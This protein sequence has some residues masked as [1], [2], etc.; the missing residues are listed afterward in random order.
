MQSFER[1]NILTSN[2]AIAL[3]QRA[4]AQFDIEGVTILGGE[5]LLQAQGLLPLLEWS[6]AEGLSV[7]LFTGYLW[8]EC[9]ANVVPGSEKLLHY[10]DVLIDGAYYQDKPDPIRN[11]VG[12]TNQR[13]I[14]LTKRYDKSIETNPNYRNLVE[15]RTTGDGVSING[16]PRTLSP[17]ASLKNE[18]TK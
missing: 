10:I 7:I 6:R 11:W 2:E 5:P 4:K 3:L 8:E 12:S 14:Y 1:R 9:L 17:I 16:C 13:F 15:F 18:V